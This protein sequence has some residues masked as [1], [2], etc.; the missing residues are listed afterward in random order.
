MC[1]VAGIVLASPQS[2]N[3]SVSVSVPRILE[4][5]HHR[6]PDA[7]G[8][9]Q[10]PDG[11]AV[12]GHN[13]LAI[14][15]L[16]DTGAQ[17][18]HDDEG[19]FV[20]IYNGELYNYK[21]LRKYLETRFAVRFRGAS[22]TEV[23]LYGIKHLGV[24]R[25]LGEA[26][27]MFAAAI[28][29]RQTRRLML[30]RD[31]AG[32]K[33]LCYALRPEGLVFASEVKALVEGLGAPPTLDDSA[34]YLYFL[35][36]YVPAP[37]TLF[38]GIKKV[39]AG[40]YLIWEPG[41]APDVRPY[42]SW[43]QGANE[44]AP[45]QGNFDAVVNKVEQHLV[46][47]LNGC[48]MSDVPLG[49]FLSGG[50]DSSLVAALARRHFGLSINTYTVGFEG[51]PESETQISEQTAKI[52]GSRHVSR[53]LK[54]ADLG[55]LSRGLIERM[56]EPNGDRSCVPTF[57]LCQ[58]A[59]S[60]VTV[61]LGGD[62]GDELFGGYG[63][64]PGLRHS[65]PEGLFPRGHD[66]A[67]AYFQASLPVFGAPALAKVG[68]MPTREVDD[69]LASASTSLLPPRN[70]EVAIRYFDFATY[71]PGAV[72]SKVDRM[73]M[74]VSLEVRTPFF[75]RALL[76]WSSVLPHEFLINGAMLKPVLRGMAQKLGL[77]HIV[78]LPKK[79]FG[80]PGA[81]LK[82]NAA[83]LSTRGAAALDV[84]NTHPLLS[85][86]MRGLGDRLRPVVGANAN[87]LWATIVLGEWLRALP[88]R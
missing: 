19:R 82:A 1:G 45:S 48:L 54:S 85:P 37:F 47:S 66:A 61:A 7:R 58:H 88:A 51:D 70:A 4:A 22:D 43:D 36:R 13:R 68:V 11:G 28:Y 31:R 33:P 12:L 18:M 55:T 35:L 23:F 44:I 14:V 86:Q 84:L 52:I 9:W 27:G 49:F 20:I 17:P 59:R 73:A 46:E 78:N 38:A 15:D 29:D 56:D 40:H 6:G 74:Q 5:Q 30:V 8:L 3:H 67:L 79:G 53:T 75:S 21:A 25:F 63:R 76:G 16:T 50:I 32:E 41:K 42:F 69:W 39:P 81:F 62:G 10:D 34:L 24:D 64:Y 72:L 57:L 65:L 87:S 26:E 71:L 83:E 2:A 60:E 77:G 80:M